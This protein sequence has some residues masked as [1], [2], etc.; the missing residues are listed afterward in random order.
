M[1]LTHTAL[2]AQREDVK[3]P[4][5]P[6]T[7]VPQLPTVERL[8]LD[9]LP[10]GQISRLWVVLAHDGLGQDIKV[11]VMVAKVGGCAIVSSLHVAV[12]KRGRSAVRLSPTAQGE[13][14]GPVLGI[15]ACLHGNELNGIP[16]IHRLFR[17]LDC[18]AMSGTVVAVPVANAPGYLRTQRGYLDGTDLNRLMPGKKNGT[19]AQ[20]YAYALMDRI[21]SCFNY[22]IDMHTASTGRVNSLYVRTNMR[23]PVTARMAILQNP[24][25]GWV[26]GGDARCGGAT[27]KS[28][29][30]VCDF[31][32]P[33]SADHCAQHRSRR[34][35]ARRRRGAR[36]PRHHGARRGAGRDRL[37][38]RLATH[39]T[40]RLPLSLHR[41]RAPRWR[42]AIRSGSTRSSSS[43][44][45]LAWRT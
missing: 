14:V 40:F 44:P 33:T 20:A 35:P 7:P 32:A 29:S 25:V 41:P 11:P 39:A 3:S 8:E 21:V 19:S 17:E 42:S 5:L 1:T 34:L 18:S 15:T 45:S 6:S 30:F 23:H 31:P 26:E 2:A 10:V 12:A 22:L 28:R 38:R 9:A 37:A 13:R 43:T 16:L 27:V 24:H 36:H 4:A